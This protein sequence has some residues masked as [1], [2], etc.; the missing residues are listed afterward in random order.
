MIDESDLMMASGYTKNKVE[1]GG[2][3]LVF[4]VSNDCYRLYVT[5]IDE[6]L[7]I[8]DFTHEIGRRE[9]SIITVG[10]INLKLL[11]EKNNLHMPSDALFLSVSLVASKYNPHF[12]MESVV[13]TTNKYHSFEVLLIYDDNGNIISSELH[14]VYYRYGFF[15]GSGK[16]KTGMGYVAINYKNPHSERE[17]PN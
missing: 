2:S 8:M 16:V 7:F 10:F 17:A 12:F 15:K 1:I 3:H 6:G 9:I 4:A 14:R 13:I 5:D 11:L